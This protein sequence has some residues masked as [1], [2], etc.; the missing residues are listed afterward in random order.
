[1]LAGGLIDG[2][3]L[4]A[5]RLLGCDLGYSGTRMIA[6]KR[7]LA[8]QRYRSMV[9]VSTMDDIVLTRALT[10]LDTNMLGPSIREAGLDL[11]NLP[12]APTAEQARLVYSDMTPG[13]RRWKDILSA[14]HSVSGVGEPSSVAEV[15]D[16]IA[17]EYRSA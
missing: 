1:M 14:G 6:A 13:P 16:Q 11:A 2:V 5:M 9:A 3:A 17:R 8:N 7:S 10:G 15:V 4:R 12:P